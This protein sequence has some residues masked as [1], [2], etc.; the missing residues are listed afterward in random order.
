MEITKEQVIEYLQETDNY[1]LINLLKE[2][3]TNRLEQ[4]KMEDYPNL[5]NLRSYDAKVTILYLLL[6][7]D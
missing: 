3:S 6:M 7:S 4:D 2:V 5:A 1:D